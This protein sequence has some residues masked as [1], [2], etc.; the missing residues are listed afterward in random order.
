MDKSDKS[1]NNLSKNLIKVIKSPVFI[2]GLIG[3]V[4]CAFTAYS[5]YKY[6]KNSCHCKHSVGER[7]VGGMQYVTVY[8]RSGYPGMGM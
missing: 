4:V 7:S 3:T 2:T 6:G 5:G 1:G 8:R